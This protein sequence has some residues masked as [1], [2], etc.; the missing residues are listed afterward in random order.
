MPHSVLITDDEAPIHEL[1]KKALEPTGARIVSAYSGEEALKQLSEKPIDLLVTDV[2]M[3]GMDGLALVRT[4]R[5]TGNKNFPVVVVTSMDDAVRESL[6]QYLD[7]SEKGQDR[8]IR[9]PFSIAQISKI[10]LEVLAR[11]QPLE[12]ITESKALEGSLSTLSFLDVIQLLRTARMT[13][14]LEFD[15]PTKGEVFFSHGDAIDARCGKVSGR[16]AFYRMLAWV[17]GEFQFIKKSSIRAERR[18]DKD[19][20]MLIMGGL[21]TLDEHRQLLRAL[22]ARVKVPV[23][24]ETFRAALTQGERDLLGAAVQEPEV[25]ALL[26]IDTRED[27]FVLRDLKALLDRGLLESESADVGIDDLTFA[28]DE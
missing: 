4:L 8:F 2:M 26:D 10:F 3:P 25:V 20:T 18:I 24:P 15:E 7:F 6:S 28:R 1:L 13:G 19:T 9:K 22:P 23:R 12:E 5:E 17:K 14:T 21:S 11:V 27:L 16:K